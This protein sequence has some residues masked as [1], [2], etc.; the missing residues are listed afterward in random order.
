VT[1]LASLVLLAAPWSPVRP[2]LVLT[3]D[4][5][6]DAAVRMGQETPARD[7]RQITWVGKD[8]MRVEEG[9]RVT[10]VRSDLKRLYILDTA[11]RTST[12]IELPFELSR[13]VPA[14][15]HSMLGQMM[16]RVKVSVSKTDQTRKVG[17]WDTS[18]YFVTMN[19]PMGT[20][21]STVWVTQD[22]SL[23]GCGLRELSAEILAATPL[24]ASIAAE[25][26]KIEGLPVLTER[27]EEVMGA[28]AVS[29][30]TVI[31][32]EQREPTPGLYDVPEGYTEK[33]YEPFAAMSG[34]G[35]HDPAPQATGPR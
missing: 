22:V 3:T 7:T 9:T 15:M 29:R 26:K 18:A 35:P 21:T 34:P 27:V 2:D 16:D 4:K 30:D 11:A 19:M 13:Y 17:E 32:V 28:R 25:M 14:E 24:G 1:P 31:S 8:R 10:I 12:T 23:E 33:P 5:H 20:M 6:A